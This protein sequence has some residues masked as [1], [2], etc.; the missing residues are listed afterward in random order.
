MGFGS[1]I[2]ELFFTI[3][4]PIWIS[5]LGVALGFACSFPLKAVPDLTVLVILSSLKVVVLNANVLFFCGCVPAPFP[6]VLP[7]QKS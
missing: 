6:S 2:S 4:K 3:T 1:I 5:Q 7:E